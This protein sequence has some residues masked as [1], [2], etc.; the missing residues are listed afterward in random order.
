MGIIFLKVQGLYEDNM[1]MFIK[2]HKRKLE[3]TRGKN[4]IFSARESW[5]HSLPKL[6]Y[7]FFVN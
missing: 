2:G 6:I 5:H 3:Q 1:K 4:I 7:K